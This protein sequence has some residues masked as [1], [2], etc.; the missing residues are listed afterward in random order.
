VH[1]GAMLTALVGVRKVAA[2]AQSG[3]RVIGPADEVALE[4]ALRLR[5]AGLLKRV[6]AAS[7]GRSRAA[8]DEAL[9]AAIAMG[10]DSAI[11]VDTTGAAAAADH[12]G[13]VAAALQQVVAAA[14]A[15]T[16]TRQEERMRLVLLGQQSAD[17]ANCQVPQLLAGRLAWHQAMFVAA[18][19]RGG[20][21]EEEQSLLAACETDA[22]TRR[23]RLR[24][25]AV[26]GCTLR[27]NTPRVA[28]LQGILRS[29]KAPITRVALSPSA[30]AS[31]AYEVLQ[32]DTAPAKPR[33]HHVAK[34]PEALIAAL[35][36]DGI[37]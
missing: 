29:R 30:A 10:A 9:R 19:E 6:V 1:S 8:C 7:V 26:V 25:P 32:T 23:V 11:H 15:T 36:A 2:G 28:T 13:V 35:R 33:K 20:G 3:P 12:P 22:G 31:A 16:A 27:L 37:F 14:A 24:L 4:A 18:L 21:G 17:T 34:T 5:E